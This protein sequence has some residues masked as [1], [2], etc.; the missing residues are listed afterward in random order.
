MLHTRNCIIVLLAALTILS[1]KKSK[2]EESAGTP[3]TTLAYAD[4]MALKPGNSWIHQNYELNTVNNVAVPTGQY[5][6]S[7][8]EK[9]TIINAKTYHKYCTS[10]GWAQGIYFLRD[11]LSYIVDNY[12]VIKF[13][14]EDFVSVFRKFNYGPNNAT[15][16]SFLVTEQMGDK[17]LAITVHAG[18]F[19]T[20]T[21]K[22]TYLFMSGPNTG[23]SIATYNRYTKNIGLVCDAT[24]YA[25]DPTKIME[26]RLER[27]HII[28]Q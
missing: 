6:S 21:F 2:T 4:Y 25:F 12:G 28:V 15:P 20:S 8:V 11:S 16:D 26:R 3:P 10:G 22:R 18:T 23:T 9:D 13:S 7:Y 27:F 14:S 19:I 1:C 17:D 24:F 5:D